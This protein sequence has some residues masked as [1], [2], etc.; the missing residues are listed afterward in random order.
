[1][2]PNRYRNKHYRG[3]NYECTN[4]VACEILK[5]SERTCLDDPIRLDRDT[6]VYDPSYPIDKLTALYIEAGVRYYGYL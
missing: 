1:M 6:W 4:L 3:R 5:P 2:N